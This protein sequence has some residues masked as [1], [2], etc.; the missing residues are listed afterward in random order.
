MGFRD[1]LYTCENIIGYTGQLHA[2]PT[3]YFMSEQ[4]QLCGHITQ[5]HPFQPNIGRQPPISMQGYSFGNEPNESGRMVLVER[6]NQKIMHTSR[7]P[8]IYVDYKENGR[9]QNYAKVI[10]TLS[11]LSQAIYALPNEKY[12]GTINLSDLSKLS[13]TKKGHA[14]MMRELKHLTRIGQQNDMSLQQMS[15]MGNLKDYS[16]VNFRGRR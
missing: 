2:F 13:S 12:L 15:T 7:N 16:R 14:N 5:Q 3:V 11:I 6:V 9:P 10:E 8:L 4:L 1:D